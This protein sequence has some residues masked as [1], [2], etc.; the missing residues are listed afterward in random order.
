MILQEDN[1][2]MGLQRAEIQEA[3]AEDQD[4]ENTSEEEQ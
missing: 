2:L 1:Y 3:L 4:D